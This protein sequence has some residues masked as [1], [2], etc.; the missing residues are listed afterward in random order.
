MAAW[1]FIQAHRLMLWQPADAT[2]VIVSQHQVF[3]AHLYPCRKQHPPA[4]LSPPEYGGT[5][6]QCCHTHA[7]EGASQ[8]CAL[9][10]CRPA[11]NLKSQ[12]LHGYPDLEPQLN[13]YLPYTWCSKVSEAACQTDRVALPA[14]PILHCILNDIT[15][16]HA[17]N[18]PLKLAAACQYSAHLANSAGSGVVQTVGRVV[19]Q[20]FDRCGGSPHS[21][22]PHWLHVRV[23]AQGLGMTHQLRPQHCPGYQRC[24]T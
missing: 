6:S 8:R 22:P 7:K 11:S 18:M 23:A 3:T 12:T 14:I 9:Q 2:I 17:C 13:R 19:K 24:Q 20:G 15:I 10:L 4:W 1:I 21:S 16:V 5:L